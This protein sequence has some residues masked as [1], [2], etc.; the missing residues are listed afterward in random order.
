MKTLKNIKYSG[1]V[2]FS[3]FLPL[4]T[5]AGYFGTVD[6]FFT[7]V[8]S[9]IGNVLI[10]VV[11]AL[12]LLIFIW[13]MFQYFILGGGDEGKR[14]QGKS[15]MLWAIIGFVLMVTIWAIVNLI[16]NGLISGTGTDR[17]N[18]DT[19]PSVDFTVSGG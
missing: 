12:A 18:I 4:A 2:L 13:G 9:F 1:L 5:N 15:L 6:T 19:L 10:P 3:L 7:N 14:G 8:Q 16:A 17:D 11:F